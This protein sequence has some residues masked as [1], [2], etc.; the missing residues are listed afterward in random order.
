[1]KLDE[2]LKEPN[3]DI[4]II[5]AIDQFEATLW[6]REISR[7]GQGKTIEEALLDLEKEL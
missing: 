5:Y 1:M 2:V 7:I 3:T 4:E 6:I